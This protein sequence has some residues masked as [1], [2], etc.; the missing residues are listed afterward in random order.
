MD[1]LN[2]WMTLFANISVIAGI[3]VLAVELQQNN[4]QL[5]IRVATTF[6]EIRTND[7]GRFAIDVYSWVRAQLGP[8]INQHNL[9]SKLAI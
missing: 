1:K 4:E 5:K 6:H 7:I 8:P 9:M 3:I 2:Q